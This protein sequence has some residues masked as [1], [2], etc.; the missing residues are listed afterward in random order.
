MQTE[1]QS[2][3][4]SVATL[5]NRASKTKLDAVKLQAGI[6]M[7]TLMSAY[8]EVASTKW[9]I[10]TQV[11]E[12]SRLSTVAPLLSKY[13]FDAEAIYN[14]LST[15]MGA[16]SLKTTFIR[17]S[18]LFD[19][20]VSV[21]ATK[22]TV[23]PFKTFMSGSSLF[24][25]SSVYLPS[26]VGKTFDE[27][28]TALESDNSEEAATALY[29]L[30]TGLRISELYK[31]T[32]VDGQ[33]MVKGKGGKLRQ[34]LAERPERVSSMEKLRQFLSQMDLTPHDLRKLTATKLA[35]EGVDLNTL[36]DVFGWSS[37]STAQV[38]L[39]QDITDKTKT[40]VQNLLK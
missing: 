40:V 24:K 4:I 16:Y 23:N 13:G 38:Y 18:A 29:L 20:A 36:K 30:K 22:T 33:L 15:K 17:L 19:F 7:D 9:S 21:N 35:S 34:V 3:N 39:Q 2:N 1:R 10:S 31:V 28:K 26:K 11:S 27:V 12:K 25:K 6:D 8:L 32:K 14:I 37:L 5:V